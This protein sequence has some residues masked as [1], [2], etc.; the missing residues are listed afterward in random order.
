VIGITIIS[1]L[2]LLVTPGLWFLSLTILHP[3]TIRLILAMANDIESNPGP[4]PNG[5][6]F[7]FSN[8]N[9]ISANN[10]RRFEDLRLC[11]KTNNIQFAAI[12][13]TGVNLT[14]SDYNIDGYHALDINLTNNTGRGMI[15]YLSESLLFKRR[16]DLE[17]NRFECMWIEVNINHKLIIVGSFY[18]SPSQTPLI[19]DQFFTSCDSMIERVLNTNADSIILGGDFNSRSRMWWLDDINS[20]EGT[21]LYDIMVKHSLSQLINEPTRI[22]P[23]SKSC[24]DLLFTNTPGYIL[25]AGVK[26]PVLGSDHSNIIASIDLKNNNEPPTV[27]RV[28]KYHLTNIDALNRAISTHNWDRILGIDDVNMMASTFIDNV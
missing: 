15:L 19:R 27:R 4:Q 5:I 1:A 22:T 25:Q 18:R 23:I 8:V 10:G 9:S 3:N 11:L 12:S 7:L 16:F 14:F 28:W 26:P 20:T 21:K 2:L 24:I 6:N 13:E 17:D